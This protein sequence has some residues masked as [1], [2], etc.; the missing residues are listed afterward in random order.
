MNETKIN[1]A[2]ER[3][4]LQQKAIW[5]DM[6]MFFGLIF[7]VLFKFL[8]GVIF[9]VILIQLFEYIEIKNIKKFYKNKNQKN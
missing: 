7:C 5:Y 1:I 6:I 3:I 8:Y 2:L 4:E 9:I